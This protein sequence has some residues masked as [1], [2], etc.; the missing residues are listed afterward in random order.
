MQYKEY[1]KTIVL[2]RGL[3]MVG[4][5]LL[6]GILVL[7]IFNLNSTAHRTLSSTQSEHMN[8]ANL[9]DIQ[10]FTKGQN[11]QEIHSA[12][13]FSKI[14]PIKKPMPTTFNS[15]STPPIF[16]HAPNLYR[17]NKASQELE[18]QAMH[19]A[20]SSNVLIS[21][22][23]PPPTE[24]VKYTKR[25]NLTSQ[26][27]PNLQAEKREFLN[28]ESESDEILSSHIKNSMTPYELQAGSIIPGVLISGIN[29][30]LPG[31]ITGQVPQRS[32]QNINTKT[33]QRA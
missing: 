21:E 5:V 3:W 30:D 23:T 29:S 27:D 20:I 25:S 2:R 33:A 12:N 6:V 16:N 31:F 18:A 26:N 32:P 10:W 4:G 13:H 22:N 24:A 19:A 11:T 15:H 7:I 8:T 17:H 14:H 9:S 28:A 1:P